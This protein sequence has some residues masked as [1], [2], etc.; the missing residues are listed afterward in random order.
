M[1]EQYRGMIYRRWYC[2]SFKQAVRNELMPKQDCKKGES[3]EDVDNT[4]KHILSR[5]FELLYISV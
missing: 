2:D 1:P 3:I 4:L 5:L